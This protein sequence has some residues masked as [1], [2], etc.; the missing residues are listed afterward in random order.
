MKKPKR[1]GRREG[2][3]RKRGPATTTMRLPTAL[4]YEIKAAIASG[5]PALELRLAKSI[6]P[7]LI[8]EWAGRRPVYRG[9]R[10]MKT[11]SGA[12]VDLGNFM[13][14]RSDGQWAIVIDGK[15]L[16]DNDFLRHLEACDPV[17]TPED[18]LSLDLIRQLSK[19]H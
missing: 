10:R 14:Q 12:L 2:A 8:R 9:S 19:P 15:L 11:G 17:N 13:W 6:V 1:G 4:A 3:G 18:L 7:Q 5:I 16:C